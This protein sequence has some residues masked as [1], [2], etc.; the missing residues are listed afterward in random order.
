MAVGVA[1]VVGVGVDVAEAVGV[2]VAVGVGDGVGTPPGA[3]MS[4]TNWRTGLKEAYGRVRRIW[5]LVGI[6]P[7]VIH[8]GKA[9]R[10]GV[11]IGRKSFSAPRDRACVLGN[12]PR[13]AAIPSVSLGTIMRETWMLR[14]HVE[15]DV[16]DID[17]GSRKAH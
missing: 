1:V 3:W 15:A 16:T 8:C 9:N 14:R 13:R 4:N 7:E 11:L 10:V 17:P 2:A 12:I 6:K 5:R